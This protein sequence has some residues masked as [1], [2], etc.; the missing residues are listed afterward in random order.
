MRPLHYYF[1]RDLNPLRYEEQFC[2][3]YEESIFPVAIQVVL[4]S[5][6]QLV[7]CLIVML[8]QKVKGH[9]FMI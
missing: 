3:I 5:Q 7:R 2:K 9:F 4:Q 1:R 6:L 8:I